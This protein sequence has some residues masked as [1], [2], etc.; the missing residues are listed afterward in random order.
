MVYVRFWFDT[1]NDR[2]NA[3][4]GWFIDDV[5]ILVAKAARPGEE[6]PMANWSCAP[7]ISALAA[8]MAWTINRGSPPPATRS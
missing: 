7:K 5:Q 1:V 8:T 6:R 2:F 3:Y 4:E